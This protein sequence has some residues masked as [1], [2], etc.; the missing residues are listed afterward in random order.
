MSER[1]KNAAQFCPLQSTT[2]ANGTNHS[3][4]SHNEARPG[5]MRPT[6][7]TMPAGVGDKDRLLDA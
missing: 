1:D 7:L 3:S 4:A 2:E 6:V 5:S